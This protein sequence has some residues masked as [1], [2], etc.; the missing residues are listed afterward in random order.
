MAQI[1]SNINEIVSSKKFKLTI[2]IS[3]AVFISIVWGY[4][5]LRPG[6]VTVT[7]DE[8][9]TNQ[10]VSVTESIPSETCVVHVDGAVVNPGVV[11]ETGEYIRVSD[12]V[13]RA[14]GLR[15]DA[16]TTAINLAA[17]LEDGAK[18]YIPFEGEEE[19]V[20]VGTPDSN[21]GESSLVNLNTATKEELQT[22]PGVGPSTADAI[23][24]ERDKKKFSSIEDLMRVGGI[25][26]K[27]F[28]KLKDKIC[29]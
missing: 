7:K 22:L 5:F 25:G 23:V 4:I 3:C 6:K 18:V 8:N 27:K 21:T 10:E 16:D 28:E 15:E 1:T 14:G 9:I 13:K 19:Q 17:K 24:E 2:V 12:A 11:E 26:E 20:S 29:V